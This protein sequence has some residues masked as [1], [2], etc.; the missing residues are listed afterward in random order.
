MV[1]FGSDYCIDDKAC[2][3]GPPVTNSF[4]IDLIFIGARLPNLAIFALRKIMHFKVLVQRSLRCVEPNQIAQLKRNRIYI[5]IRRSQ[6]S[7][8]LK[9]VRYDRKISPNFSF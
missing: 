8:S 6:Y 4:L 3:H 9:N 2:F 5:R 7:K 1:Q